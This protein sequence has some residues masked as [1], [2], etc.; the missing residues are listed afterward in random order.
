MLDGGRVLLEA[1]FLV[2]DIKRVVRERA[3]DKSLGE[4]GFNLSFFKACWDIVKV[5]LVRAMNEF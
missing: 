2:E 1:L 4:D 5:D 3:E